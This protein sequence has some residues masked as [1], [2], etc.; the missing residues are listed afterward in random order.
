M[1]DI[2]SDLQVGRANLDG[3]TSELFVNNVCCKIGDD[4]NRAVL[5]RHCTTKNGDIAARVLTTAIGTD[6]YYR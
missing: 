5:G 2:D 4:T 6:H 3:F 1:R